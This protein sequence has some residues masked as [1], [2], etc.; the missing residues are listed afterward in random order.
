ME[1]YNTLTPYKV[2]E[3]EGIQYGVCRDFKHISAYRGL[4]QVTHN[5]I[6]VE[7][8]YVA[9]ETPNPFTTNSTVAYYDVPAYQENRLDIMS[10]ELLGDATYSW[11]LSY[12]NSISDGY[13]ALTGQRIVV[14]RAITA[15][16]NKQE[17][18]APVNP[19]AL[20]LGTE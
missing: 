7:D 6:T 16:F 18:L 13:T 5:P 10:E 9:L 19:T 14:P 12:F 17:I 1:F 2:I 11:V 3:Y 20:N 8:R 15:L 4:R